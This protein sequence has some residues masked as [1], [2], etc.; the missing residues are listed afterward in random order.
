MD[1]STQ[2]VLEKLK[3]TRDALE[4]TGASPQIAEVIAQAID[5]VEKNG[6][7]AEEAVQSEAKAKEDYYDMMRKMEKIDK[8]VTLL[9]SNDLR[10]E[11]RKLKETIEALDDRCMEYRREILDL[12]SYRAEL[13]V[14]INKLEDANAHL[15]TQQKGIERVNQWF[16]EAAEVLKL[17][18]ENRMDPVQ[19]LKMAG[20]LQM[21]Q[22]IP[23]GVVDTMALRT[24]MQE[25]AK[26]RTRGLSSL[27]R[28]LEKDD[29]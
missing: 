27:S 11:V 24:G 21:G 29:K 3:K 17:G 7:R 2:N 13:E 26:L 16:M 4:M 15:R 28:V 25:V 5:V 10:P 9:R 19:C 14:K 23:E 22:E 6:V 12:K 20:Y 1:T 18:V 8:E